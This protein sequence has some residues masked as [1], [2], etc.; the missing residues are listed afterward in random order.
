M[1]FLKKGEVKVAKAL[2]KVANLEEKLK[3]LTIDES[4]EA[5]MAH[6]RWAT[7]G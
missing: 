2:G 5:G 1:A 3:N 4:F 6:T 7:H